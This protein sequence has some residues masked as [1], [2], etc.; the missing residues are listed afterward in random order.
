MGYNIVTTTTGFVGAN[1]L[2]PGNDST[3]VQLDSATGV[4]TTISADN[5]T[6]SSGANSDIAEDIS[7][8][9]IPL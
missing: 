7:K 8:P 1:T 3:Y 9:Q 6:I 4:P 5:I 2:E